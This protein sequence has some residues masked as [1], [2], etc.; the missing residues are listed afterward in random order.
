MSI[1]TVTSKAH[2][3]PP[4][5]AGALARLWLI[6]P[7]VLFLVGFYLI[8]LIRTVFLSLDPWSEGAA[9]YTK[10]LT[11]PY[12][13]RVSFQT[14]ALSAVVALVSLILGYPIAYFLVR[15][16]KRSASLIMFMLVAPL[17]TSIVMR[18]F[19]WR[20]IFARR[21]FLNETLL[22]FGIIDRPLTILDN[23]ISAVIGLVHVLIPFMVLAI[24]ASLQSVSRSLE[25][26]S[27]ILGASAPSTFF[28]ITFPLTFDGIATG[29]I[30]VFMLA[31]GSFVTVLL[32]G[33]GSV[34][35]LPLLI[36]QQFNTTRDFVFASAM[37]NV[38]LVL[39]VACLSLQLWLI[40]RKGV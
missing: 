25:E 13:L 5:K 12:Y 16:A 9:N 39:A 30:L 17:L 2:A 24:A 3:R 18:T 10:L 37:S 14:L 28:R 36:Y 40:R 19:G 34:T 23:P 6:A 32:L 33:G 21:G 29:I 22:S 20:I 31:N 38:L 7:A 11:D 4:R 1:A 15:K 26:S 35:T 8:P 27:R